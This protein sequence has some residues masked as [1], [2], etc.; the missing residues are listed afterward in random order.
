MNASKVDT[1]ESCS[2]HINPPCSVCVDEEWMCGKCG[3]VY[4][5]EE[6]AESCCKE[7]RVDFTKDVEEYKREHLRK[8]LAKCTP[9]QQK[10]FAR[11]YKSVDEIPEENMKR[12]SEQIAA[13]ILK[14]EKE[15]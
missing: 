5:G 15:Q 14:N 11:M 2:C 7:K 4:E 9:A 13:T 12:A 8:E 3:E 10:L 1:E 6:E